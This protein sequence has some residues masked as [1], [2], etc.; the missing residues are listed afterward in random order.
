MEDGGWRARSVL[1][2]GGPPPLSHRVGH[3]FANQSARG[4]AQS[5]TWR[6][7][8]ALLTFLVITISV[9][10]QSYSIGWAKI[11]TGIGASGGGAYSV[12]GSIGQAVA[13]AV[14]GGNYTLANSQWGVIARVQMIGVSSL[15][16]TAAELLLDGNFQ[17][18]FQGNLD[19]TYMLQAS[20]NLTDWVTVLTFTCTNSPMVVVDPDA[21]SY[22]HRFYRIAQ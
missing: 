4:L 10:A 20:T 11:A 3:P 8:G 17:V 22:P 21:G 2:C 12:S 15:A 1:D 14:S 6:L 13:G 19:Q 18:G 9:R 16:I 7:I 5:K